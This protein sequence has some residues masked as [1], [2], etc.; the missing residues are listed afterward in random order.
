MLGRLISYDSAGHGSLG[1]VAGL[2]NLCQGLQSA[3]GAL[4]RWW[5]CDDKSLKDKV[6]VLSTI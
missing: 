6:S 5:P 2:W 4:I 3:S 1:K